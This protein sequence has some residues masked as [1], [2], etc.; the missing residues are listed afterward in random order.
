MLPILH[1]PGSIG[2]DLG[3]LSECV[4]IPGHSALNAV[5]A[6]P[7]SLLASIHD[8][9]DTATA[10]LV[11]VLVIPSYSSSAALAL[12]VTSAHSHPFPLHA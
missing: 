6:A 5:S 3:N 7:G 2:P 1:L 8:G 12:R 4:I 11:P 9:C 10:E